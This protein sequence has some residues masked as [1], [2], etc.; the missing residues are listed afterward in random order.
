MSYVTG[1]GPNAELRLH[2]IA[3]VWNLRTSGIHWDEVSESDSRSG[4]EMMS[5]ANVPSR[6]SAQGL[7][8]FVFVVLA[9]LWTGSAHA[10][11]SGVKIASGTTFGLTAGPNYISQPDGQMVYSWGYGCTTTTADWTVAGATCPGMQVPGPTLIIPEGVTVT[12]TLTNHL[13]VGAGNA[14]IIFPGL[15]VAASGGQAG[16]LTQEALPNGTVSYTITAP[17][18]GTYAYASGTQPDLQVEMGLYG[19]IIVTPSAAQ[20]GCGST[21]AQSLS[22]NAYDN[23]YTCYDRE[24]M[25]QFSEMSLPIHRQVEAQVNAGATTL[26]IKIDPYKPNYFLINGRSMP[27][28]MDS[29][30]SPAYPHQ[31]YNANPHMHPGEL[32]LMRV[33]GHGRIQHPFHFHGNHARIVARDAHLLVSQTDSVTPAGPLLFAIATASGQTVDGI[34]QWTGKG[35]GYDAYGHGVGD[36]P[37][38]T[39]IPDVN[40]YNTVAPLYEWCADHGHSLQEAQYTTA[41]PNVVTDGLWYGGSPYLGDNQLNSKRLLPPGLAS[42]NPSAGF[43]YMWHSHDEREITTN[44]VFP[45]GMMVMMI[46]D[47][48]NWTI[49]ENQ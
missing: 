16:L 4:R 37:M 5:W 10:A 13:P 1:S 2:E 6:R 3:A 48:P 18:P 32:T 28:D 41:D 23:P 27:D 19:A 24:Y 40:G 25:F 7:L 9:L 45:G 47:P 29:P 49:D 44:D 30:Y 26:N 34:F 38:T 8:S 15:N 12:I 17:T 22:A 42:Q 46:V 21:N 33:I 35:L 31:P 20:T 11:I 39:C 36:I 14:S 43:A